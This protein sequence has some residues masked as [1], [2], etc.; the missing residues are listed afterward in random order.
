MDQFRISVESDPRPDD[1]DALERGLIAHNE[2]QDVPRT[3]LPLAVFLRDADGRVLGGVAGNTVWGWLQIKLAWID[4]GLRGQGYGAQLMRAAE[5]EAVARGCR[6]AWV[7]TFTF[8]AL[9]FYLKQGYTIFGELENFPHGH[10]RY[11]LK[12]TNLPSG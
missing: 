8:Q 9:G 1:L 2:Q 6:Q 7:D 5:R 11:F 3:L 4:D 10:T 12:K